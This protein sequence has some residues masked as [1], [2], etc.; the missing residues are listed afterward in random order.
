MNLTQALI[1]NKGEPVE[2]LNGT[3]EETSSE[4]KKEIG[5]ASQNQEVE[6]KPPVVGPVHSSEEV[7]P[8]R[9]GAKGLD[10]SSVKLRRQPKGMMFEENTK[11]VPISTVQVWEAYQEVRKHG[12]SAGV[13]KLSLKDFEAVRQKELYKVWNRMASG[14]YFPPPVRRHEIPKPDGKKRKLGIP[15][16][17]DKVA[18]EVI[19]RYLEP[20]IE[21]HFHKNSFA[22]RKNRNA[23]QAIEQA[24]QQCYKRAWVID[25]D[26]KGFFDNLNHELV[27]K[28][29]QNHTQEKWVL[30]Y[31][32]RW[33]KAPVKH[34]DGTLEYPI[35]GSPQGGVI[36]PLLANM[37]L[38]YTF[39]LWMDINC[40]SVEFER[41]ADDIIVHCASKRQA[42]YLLSKIRERFLQCGLKLHPD[43]TQIV[44][45]K[46]SNRK[47]NHEHVSFDF[48]G[49]TFK[50]KKSMSQSTG[51]I[52]TSFGP[53]RISRKS[54]KKII[55]II[56]Q[57]KLHRK[58]TTELPELAK[59]MHAHLQ[60]WIN[61]YYGR[62][63]LRFLQPA[64]KYLNERLTA[65]ACK[66]YKRFRKSMQR[67][68]QWLREIYRDYPNMF[69]HWKYGFKP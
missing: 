47:E 40:K 22:Y 31:I 48:L 46:N 42:E 14:S 68:R 26:I 55:D 35:K 54:T 20:R 16:V 19:R 8:T 58:T 28:A 3:T 10:S 52:F 44:Y 24:T 62:F 49:L 17:G 7:S 63:D 67:A 32:E 21:K 56:R 36:S 30:M 69:V 59:E 34:E 23:Q 9:E 33:L 12:K 41:Y 65:W 51:E 43:K 1:G 25:L 27:M 66:R 39:D 13:D 50:P 15:T 60:G 61:G 4:K 2:P 37:Y 6:V 5:E 11:S 64:M 57:K 53:D 29:V 38:H 45:C 18:Q